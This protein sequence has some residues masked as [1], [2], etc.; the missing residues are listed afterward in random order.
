MT[1]FGKELRKIRLDLGITLFDM[2]SAIGISSAMLSSVETGRKAAPDDLVERLANVYAEV[3]N[4]KEKF[5]RLADQTKKEVRLTLDSREDA[6]E[7]A[8]AFAR[9]FGQLSQTQISQ[10]MAVFDKSR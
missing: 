1:N 3:R 10:M 9:N 6:S 2:A 8:V 7:L 5:T 4:Q